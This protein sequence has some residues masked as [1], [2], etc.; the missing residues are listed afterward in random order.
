MV[1]PLATDLH[2]P[3]GN[4]SLTGTCEA[5][6]LASW[7]AILQQCT[8]ARFGVSTGVV[9]ANNVREKIASGEIV[10]TPAPSPKPATFTLQE[11]KIGA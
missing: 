2:G 5:T 3:G 8:T 6:S 4:V 1:E 9:A 10:P 7:R 11:A